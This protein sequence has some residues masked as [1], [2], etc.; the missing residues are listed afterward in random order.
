MTIS[1]LLKGILSVCLALML[2]KEW[3]A[4][5]CITITFLTYM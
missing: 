3:E 2:S 1:T 5:V 4:F